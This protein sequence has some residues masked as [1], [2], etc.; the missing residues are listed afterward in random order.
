M[1]G[2]LASL[3]PGEGAGVAARAAVGRGRSI[4]LAIP[5]LSVVFPLELNGS[6]SWPCPGTTSGHRLDESGGALR[7][8][9]RSF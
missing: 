9:R 5:M 2:G 7:A 4:G 3:A 8:G 1:G 6:D